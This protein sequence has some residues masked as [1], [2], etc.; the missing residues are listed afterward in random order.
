MWTQ[1]VHREG[2]N[3]E[4][5][6]PCVKNG[7]ICEYL[8]ALSVRG[9]ILKDFK[10]VCTSEFKR[11]SV[12][13]FEIFAQQ[14]GKKKTAEKK[15]A[16]SSSVSQGNIFLLHVDET[17]SAGVLGLVRGEVCGEVR[18]CGNGDDDDDDNHDHA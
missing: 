1:T 3:R 8:I 9:V 7:L 18:K 4:K 6:V 10:V 12:S 2:A 13:D 11:G 14:Q 15:T 16:T 17:Y 5:R